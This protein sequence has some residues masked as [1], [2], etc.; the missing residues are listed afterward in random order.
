MTPQY[1][2]HNK[3]TWDVTQKPGKPKTRAS[4]RQKKLKMTRPRGF[5]QK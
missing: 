3:K 1:P 5:Q 2:A 4:H